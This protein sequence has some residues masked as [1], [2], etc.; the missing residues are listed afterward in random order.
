MLVTSS[1]RTSCHVKDLVEQRLDQ[2][3]QDEGLNSTNPFSE[4]HAERRVQENFEATEPFSEGHVEQRINETNATKQPLSAN[5]FGTE[6]DQKRFRIW[7]LEVGHLVCRLL[8]QPW[9]LSK[10]RSESKQTDQV[11][12]PSRMCKFQ[13]DLQ[14]HVECTAVT[15]CQED[16]TYS[17]QE[18]VSLEL[19]YD[20][21]S[22]GVA[23]LNKST[24]TLHLLGPLESNDATPVAKETL[25]PPYDFKKAE[26]GP[27]IVQKNDDRTAFPLLIFSR[28]YSFLRCEPREIPGVAGSKRSHPE[29]ETPVAPVSDVFKIAKRIE[30]F[31]DIQKG[32]KLR[33]VNGHDDAEYHI[34]R[35][36]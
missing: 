9:D 33:V 29:K 16:P 10:F 36:A 2:S 12:R 5:K 24:E 4:G 6:L 20:N 25:V 7:D 26:P 11:E 19:Y 17:M 18:A 3:Q 31:H 35:F 34:V 22:D 30:T 32:Q 15:Q 8:T 13:D 28:R 14:R 23:V 21:Q 1:F 27:W